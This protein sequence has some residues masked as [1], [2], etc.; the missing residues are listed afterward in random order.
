[1]LHLLVSGTARRQEEKLRLGLA[2]SCL[3][4]LKCEAGFGTS[5]LTSTAHSG[6]RRHTSG[7]WVICGGVIQA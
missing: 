3:F 1:M 7:T 5:Y 6:S 2:I 4:V